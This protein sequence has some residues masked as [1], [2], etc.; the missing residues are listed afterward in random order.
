MNV[1]YLTA[2]ANGLSSE[3]NAG[4]KFLKRRKNIRAIKLKLTRSSITPS[5]L[6][7]FPALWWHYDS[8]THIPAAAA[9]PFVISTIRDYLNKGGSLLLSLL[10]AQFVVDLG[11]EA[12]RPNVIARD[13]WDE[14]CWA[15]GFPDIRG[16]GSFRGHPIFDELHGSAYTW[17][18][19]RGSPFAGTFYE[20]PILPSGGK[21]VAVA[22]EYI[23]LREDWVMI[24]EYKVGKGRI[25][26]VGSFFFFSDTANRFR[27]HLERLAQ[28]CLEYL[29]SKRRDANGRQRA[30][31]WDFTTPEVLLVVAK[32]G[33]HIRRKTTPW[34]PES[35]PLRLE[36]EQATENFFD[37]GG[38]RILIMG[39]EK[40]GIEEVWVHPIR[41]LHKVR[42]G[43]GI[44]NSE[45]SRLETL[46]PHVVVRPESFTR[47]FTIG[48][49]T[50]EERTFGDL[51]RPGGAVH[52]SIR[53]DQPVELVCTGV[54]DLRMMWPVSESA[55]G[56][57]N[58]CWH[59]GLQA[60]MV[61]GQSGRLC[62]LIGCSQVPAEYTVGHFGE[63]KEKS[64]SLEGNRTDR[65]QVAFG[66]KWLFPPGESVC[67]IVFAGSDQGEREARA[68]YVQLMRD[69]SKSYNSQVA[70][71]NRLLKKTR[72]IGVADNE[73]RKA[74][75][76]AVAA[77]DR[78]FVTTPGLGS[79]LMAGFGTTASGW[80]GGH[81]I[82][83]RPGYAWYFGRDSVWTALAMLAYGEKKKVRSVLEFLGRYQDITGKILHECTTS[84][85]IH[86]DAADSTPLY[87]LLMGRYLRASHDRA[88]AKKEYSR[89]VK[90]VA[91]CFSTDAD[92]DHLI[93]NTNVGHGWIE[94]GPLFPS[95]AEFYLNA[96]W[97]A[98][99]GE[100]S[101]IAQ[102]LGKTA[103]SR[104][105]KREARKVKSILNN[106]FWNPDTRSY[107]F[108]KN[109]DG[110][111]NTTETILPA[112]AMYLGLADK[113]K[114][115]Q[116]LREFT[117]EEFATEWGVRLIARD[118]PMY[119]PAGYHYGSVWPLFTGWTALAEL[120]LGDRKR[121]MQ[122]L[123]RNAG[124][125]TQFALGYM[126]EV[127]HG[128][129]CELAGVCAHQAWSEA[130]VILGVA[131]GFPQGD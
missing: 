122:H 40:K 82:S 102:H 41:I 7:N 109:A 68:T 62:S 4:W 1:A 99:L 46:A 33:K 50:I 45:I 90:A 79:S 13:S 106:E 57:L 125:H 34:Q 71:F 44:G 93:E 81:E 119:N 14:E 8:S 73:L 74:Y 113:D 124:L 31:Y 63:I 76:W 39:T 26:T 35:G 27:P 10:A 64:G 121:G 85:F 61:T 32:A 86:Y 54:I 29:S 2:K 3:E 123:M 98:A 108:S 83:G 9:D 118:E 103:E 51:N 22:R 116:C 17:N 128:E 117:T 36:R 131:A 56:S 92:G 23:R 100:A 18:P 67:T 89:L 72:L 21:I 120:T 42:I 49:T 5:L 130:M 66:F 87:I 11:C 20:F 30:T 12:V 24:T 25:L 115:E 95:H 19:Q 88:F 48:T 96:C 69:P 91:F 111:F 84:G 37:V 53:S 59:D 127:L 6:R 38:R 43:L 107:N 52:F 47:E 77:T 65:V 101:F 129:R 16:F 126:P 112:V 94:G 15:Q 70:H 105:W 60:V 58:C 78:F 114:S 28:N 97:A 80:N 104:R 75:R 110:T 55:T